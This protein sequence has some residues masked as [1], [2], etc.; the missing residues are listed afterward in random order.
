[1]LARFTHAVRQFLVDDDAGSVSVETVII[2]PILLWVYVATFVIFDGFRTH[3]QNV[4]AAYT[5]GDMLSRETNAID[6]AYLEGLSDVFDFL[7][8]GGNPSHLRVTQ[9]R[10]QGSNNRHRLIG[11]MPPTATIRPVCSTLI[12]PGSRTVCHR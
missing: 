9:I 12:W 6:N 2:M 3:N 1:M 11:P 7:T 5:I 10:W 4:K 8:F